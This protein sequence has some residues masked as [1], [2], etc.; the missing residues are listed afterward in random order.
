MH[1]FE[2]SITLYLAI[3]DLK[4][5]IYNHHISGYL[6]LYKKSPLLFHQNQFF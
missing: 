5:M 3:M 6:I 4:Q 1:V 2:M